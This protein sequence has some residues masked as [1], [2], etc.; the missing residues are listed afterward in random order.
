MTAS[1]EMS[2]AQP[3][4]AEVGAGAIGDE[5]ERARRRQELGALLVR[6]REGE[7]A[8][9]DQIV[10]LLMPLV[11]NVARAGGTPPDV[12]P[13]VVQNV[14]LTFLQKLAEIRSPE[15][16]AGWLVVVTRR[17][18]GRMR[19]AARRHYPVDQEVFDQ[20]PDPAA[21]I[22][23]YVA[24]HEEHTS[25]WRNLRELD[26]RCQRLLRIVAFADKPDYGAISRDL[27][28]P[29]GSI[30]PTRQRC[31]ATLR[32]RLAADPTWSER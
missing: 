15:A 20:Q 4:P 9:V 32:R 26:E 24:E 1:A 31:L 2:G 18:A 10:D 11:W 25:L 12:A 14:W 8:A 17:E 3:R 21:E 6:A 19:D 28:M 13:D 22:A 7:R 27:S 30:G 23:A 16:L 29:T 5:A